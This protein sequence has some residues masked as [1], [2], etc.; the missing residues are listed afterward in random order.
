LFP[1]VHR[2]KAKNPRLLW[3]SRVLEIICALEF[4]STI[5]QKAGVALANGLPAIDRRV[6]HQFGKRGFHF[7]NRA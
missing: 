5:T 2:L 7:F 4:H 1:F 6:L 3:Q